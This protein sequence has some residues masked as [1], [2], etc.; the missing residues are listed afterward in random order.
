MVGALVAGLLLGG[1]GVFGAS[2]A[3]LLG[4]GTPKPIAV[5]V[6]KLPTTFLGLTRSDL[7][8]S[9]DA[10][11]V[12]AVAEATIASFE[13]SY[14]APG[15]QMGYGDKAA[16]ANIWVQNGSLVAPV[17][18]V[19]TSMIRAQTVSGWLEVPG[20]ATTTCRVSLY[21][22]VKLSANPTAADVAAGKAQ[23][24]GGKGDAFVVC[25]RRDVARNVSVQATVQKWGDSNTRGEVAQKL[26]AALD[27]AFPALTK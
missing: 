13:K 19:D 1:G 7:D 11:Q 26:A 16:L 23:V 6:D 12:R 25:V 20:S 5:S 22:A 2:A 4:A 17:A 3:G 15:V 21:P 9:P 14:G 27:E 18:N 10:A 8:G 24:I